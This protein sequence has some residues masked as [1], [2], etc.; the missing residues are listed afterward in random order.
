[1]NE[2]SS[3]LVSQNE[4]EKFAQSDDVNVEDFGR[5]VHFSEIEIEIVDAL[6]SLDVGLGFDVVLLV[7]VHLFVERF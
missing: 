3:K 6:E 1:M 4:N 7:R 2:V 5:A